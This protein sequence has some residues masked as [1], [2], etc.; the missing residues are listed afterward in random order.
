[1]KKIRAK[2]IRNMDTWFIFLRQQKNIFLYVSQLIILWVCFKNIFPNG[3]L[4]T[5]GDNFSFFCNN[6]LFNYYKYLWIGIGEGSFFTIFSYGL[7]YNLIS[8]TARMLSLNFSNEI[9]LYY[10]IFLFG[11]FWSFYCAVNMLYKDN[12]KKNIVFAVSLL[13]AFNLYTLYNF[14]QGWGVAP[15]LFLYIVLPLIFAY[16]YI[17]FEDNT[18][19][20]HN[21]ALLGII[22]FLTNISNGNLAFFVSLSIILFSMMVLMLIL[23]RGVKIAKVL[24]YGLV[25]LLATFWSVIP[26]IIDMIRQAKM[27]SGDQSIHNLSDWILWQAVRFP[28]VFYFMF[29]FRSSYE[30]LP[31]LLLGIILIISAIVGLYKCQRSKLGILLSFLFVVDILFINKGKGI[32]GDST[33]LAIFNNPLLGSLRSFDKTAIFLPFLVIMLIADYCIKK[34]NRQ[35]NINLWI[36]VTITLISVYPF[37]TGGIQ[38]SYSASLKKGESYLNADYSGLVRIPNEYFEFSEKQNGLLKDSKILGVPYNV[39]NSVGWV[40]YPKWKLVGVDPTIQ[41]FDKS[42]IQFDN[43]GHFGVW[44]FGEAWNESVDGSWIMNFAGILNTDYIV[45]HKDVDPRFIEETQKK[46]SSLESS[47]NIKKVSSNDFFDLYRIKNNFMLS[48]IY[49]PSN[50]IKSDNDV[51]GLP[52]IFANMKENTAIFLTSQNVGKEELIKSLSQGINN[53]QIEYKKINPIK[54]R[55]IVHNAKSVFPLILSESYHDGWRAYLGD[56][57]AEN[58]QTKDTLVSQVNNNYKIFE[59][60][61]EDQA[62]KDELISYI[63][64]GLISTLGNSKEKIINYSKWVDGK[65]VLDHKENYKIGFVSNDIKGTIQNDNLENGS[66]AETWFQKSIDN[67]ENHLQANGYANSWIINPDKVCSNNAKCIKNADGTY[68]MEIVVEL[69]PQRLYY[70][71][72]LISGSTLIIAISYLVIIRRRKKLSNSFKIK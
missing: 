12:K 56:Y 14:S 1:M 39:I 63:N 20:L 47:G 45:Y 55:V 58:L 11:S 9:F 23:N 8:E 50:L 31:V 66:I 60:N 35:N 37:F 6:S 34:E 59:D 48:H 71:G 28:D 18:K 52:G 70:L 65:E 51:S 43:P 49:V 17:Y 22:F 30:K 29:G 69:W 46:I 21:L 44:N 54:Y 5:L 32:L 19:S 27:F 38:K 68:N 4:L 64:S 41:L 57:K 3:Y 61:S 53:P 2:L 10:A 62:S 16:T 7:F 33:I 72:I 25:Y 26:Q 42:I 24:N 36:V 40:N 15:F 67:N 13:Y